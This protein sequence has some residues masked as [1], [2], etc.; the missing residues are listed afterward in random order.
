MKVAAF[1]VGIVCRCSPVFVQ[2]P[3]LRNILMKR[4]RL[5][6]R[7]LRTGGRG[8]AALALAAPF[9]CANPAHAQ[10]LSPGQA[11]AIAKEA[12][13]YGFPLVD[14][15]RIQYTYF[16]DKNSREYKG[17][18]N[19]LNSAARVFTPDDKAV[20]TPNSDTPYSSLGADLRTEPLVLT[21]PEV[22]KGRYY[23]LQFIDMYT[24]NFA[25]VG[26]RATGNGAGRYLL[27][28]PNWKGVKPKGI[29]SVIRS[30]TD[31]AFVLYRTQLFNPSD[32]ENVKRIQAEYKVEPLSAY[33]GKTAP[34]A[35]PPVD[36]IQSLTPDEERSSIRFFNVLNF[37]LQFC[38]ASPSE[39]DLRARLA[40]LGIGA[41]K[42]FDATK[43]APDMQK[44]LQAGLAN[45]WAEYNDYK[46][47]VIDKGASS[48]ADDFGT[49]AYLK[50]NYMARMA[51]AV[52]G[53]YGN[54]KAEALYPIYR[55]DAAGKALSGSKR[56]VLH[57]A[58][59]EL[60]PVNAF[61]SLTL[62]E[63]PSS[64][65]YAN[66]LNRYLINSAM[67]PTLT[68]DA[69][70]GL[71]LYVQH[72]SPGDEHRVN[73]LPAPVGP[74]FVAMRLYWPKAEAL[75]GQWKAPLMQAVK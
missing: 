13:V 60:P 45:G 41:G 20:Q 2:K 42:S 35:A 7:T 30:E 23:S 38:P 54:S 8:V 68:R 32:I 52:L 16:V 67:L 71:T 49:R 73:W 31:Y 12:T 19:A 39:K 48:S 25:Y 4:R 47:K 17:P 72:E 65:L 69:D 1:A 5:L 37:V 36:F 62:Y 57:F 56:Y 34:P 55:A 59:D 6:Y 40:K 27:A 26:S 75:A 58:R 28:G 64:L 3:D 61:W 44:A 18:W 66:S 9:V 29:K 53:I 63:L 51:G 10:T 70:G 33:L 43:L 46:A 21:V 14:S 50:S 11:Q 22:D 74:F 15:Y 24:F